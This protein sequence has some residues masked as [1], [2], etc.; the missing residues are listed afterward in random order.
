[1]PYGNMRM[2]KHQFDGYDEWF[3]LSND[4]DCEDLLL[5]AHTVCPGQ[6]HVW[7]GPQ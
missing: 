6:V 3:V 2:G 1:M 4:C 7:D 5:L